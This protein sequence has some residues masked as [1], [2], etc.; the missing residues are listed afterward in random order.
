MRFMCGMN[1][2]FISQKT[3]FFTVTHLES[4]NHTSSCLFSNVNTE[5]TCSSETF[6]DFQ[7]TKRRYVP[8]DRRWQNLISYP[9]VFPIGCLFSFYVC[10]EKGRVRFTLLLLNDFSPFMYNVESVANMHDVTI[11]LP[12][13]RY[14]INTT[15]V[16]YR[17]WTGLLR[18]NVY[19]LVWC[20]SV[21]L[22][23]W[24][25]WELLLFAEVSFS[26]CES[27]QNGTMIRHQRLIG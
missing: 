20:A 4:A 2:D 12:N 16:I 18:E 17:E 1:W 9:G 14:D 7:Q 26:S 23:G 27:F 22:F 8:E 13:W 19:L 24:C 21:N 3:A 6:V 11:E 25:I 10:A 5:A 15:N